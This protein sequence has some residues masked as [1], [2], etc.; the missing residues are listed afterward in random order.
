MLPRPPCAGLTAD[1]I[2]VTI[3]RYDPVSQTTG[4]CDCSQSGCDTGAGGP[5]PDYIVV[6]IPNGYTVTPIIPFLT[7]TPIPLKPR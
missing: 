4:A 2:Q 6:S 1:M 7:L 5:A 3:E